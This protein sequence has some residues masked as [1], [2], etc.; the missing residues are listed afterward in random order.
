MTT[1][2]NR[3]IAQRALQIKGLLALYWGHALDERAIDALATYSAQLHVAL[4]G[5]YPARLLP[6]GG[7]KILPFIR[8]G[9]KRP[10]L[11]KSEGET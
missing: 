9:R 6:P 10:S 5:R 3:E 7:A 11:K 1:I 8:K 2:P 4:F